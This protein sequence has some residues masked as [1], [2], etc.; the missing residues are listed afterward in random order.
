[1][2]AQLFSDAMNEI[3]E[4]Y[5]IEAVNFDF[6]KCKKKLLLLESLECQGKLR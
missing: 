5:I 2:N 3:N 6:E 4:K 1:M